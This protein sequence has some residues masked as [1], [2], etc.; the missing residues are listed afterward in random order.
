M[1]NA[2]ITD[3]MIKLPRW[4]GVAL[5]VGAFSLGVAHYD[6]RSSI[7]RLEVEM[8]AARKDGKLVP[9]L[10]E[11]QARMAHR[12]DNS[13]AQARRLETDLRQALGNVQLNLARICAKVGAEC[14]D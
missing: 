1:T 12:M 3:T 11:R 6:A 5:V 8:I 2:E 14:Q 10:V 7:D 9:L 4:L 13:E